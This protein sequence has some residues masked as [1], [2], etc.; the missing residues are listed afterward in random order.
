MCIYIYIH[1]H[2]YIL[3]SIYICIHTTQNIC[4]CLCN[5]CIFF[6]YRDADSCPH[7]VARLSVSMRKLSARLRAED[8][9]IIALK[10]VK[11]GDFTRASRKPIYIG[12]QLGYGKTSDFD[13]GLCPEM[14]YTP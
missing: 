7:K 1:I 9:E 14:R 5:V 8:Q 6:Q 11:I 12:M 2:A 10:K 4:I 13:P 3:P